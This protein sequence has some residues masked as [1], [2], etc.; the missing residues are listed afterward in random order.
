MIADQSQ[1]TELLGEVVTWDSRAAELDV[2]KIR[3]ALTAAGLS[4]DVARDLNHRSAFSR[5]TKHLK[6]SR[7]IDKVKESKSGRITFQLTKKENTGDKIDFSYETQVTLDTKTGDIDSDDPAIEA[8]A[9]K[10]YAHAMQV[11]SASDITRMTQKLFKDNADLF[12][13]NPTKGVAYF[14]PE[15]HRP[16][17]A[18][19]QLFLS[20][21][22]GTLWRFPVPKGTGEGNRSVQEAVSTGLQ[23][24]LVELNEAVD[25]W[26]D[27]TR[28]DTMKRGLEKFKTLQHKAESYAEYLQSEQASLLGKI[29]E[30]KQKLVE[31]ATSIRPEKESE[32]A[33]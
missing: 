11:R 2:Q 13:I 19:V 30:A 7:S 22:G 15:S 20:A 17:T 21:V 6:E 3:D 9:R 33:A 29:D 8:E 4:D 25:N 12:P 1:N 27:T 16:F 18:Q 31:R 14:I 24:V 32:T 10:L 28:E 23:A 26:D 5:A